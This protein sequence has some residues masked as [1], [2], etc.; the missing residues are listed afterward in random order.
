[1]TI[2]NNI[3]SNSDIMFYYAYAGV[4]ASQVLSV[5]TSNLNKVF[6]EQ[7][8]DLGIDIRELA[9][10]SAEISNKSTQTLFT[11]LEQG[12]QTTNGSGLQGTAATTIIARS[13]HD[14]YKS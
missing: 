9:V 7:L 12:I 13:I 10:S 8:D 4:Q 6:L 11:K 2:F 3:F 1:M 14:A 5:N